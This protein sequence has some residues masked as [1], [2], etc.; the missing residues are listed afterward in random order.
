MKQSITK[1]EKILLFL[2]A[3][4]LIVYLSVQFVI[5]PAFARYSDLNANLDRLEDERARVEADIAMLPLLRVEN[6]EAYERF[7]EILEK[8]PELIV[9]EDIDVL[10]TNLVIRQNLNP[11]M[12]NISSPRALVMQGEEAGSEIFVLVTVSMSLVGNFNSVQHLVYEVDNIN[13]IRITNLN[14]S[15][16]S[17]NVLDDATTSVTFELTFIN[18]VSP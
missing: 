10:M 11:T 12:L 8:Y 16:P 15:L 1:R 5:F 7:T 3:L 9:S 4:V 18:P 13:F 17:S 6:A 14:Y 2:A